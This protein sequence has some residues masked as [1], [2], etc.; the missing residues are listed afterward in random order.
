VGEAD[1]KPHGQ[2]GMLRA[3]E[4]DAEAGAAAVAIADA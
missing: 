3:K 4:E 2:D 1:G